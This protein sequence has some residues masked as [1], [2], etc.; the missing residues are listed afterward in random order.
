VNLAS[1]PTTDTSCTVDPQV[2]GA[3]P[4]WTYVTTSQKAVTKPIT[5][6]VFLPR[7][8]RVRIPAGA[9]TATG[10]VVLGDLNTGYAPT[11]ASIYNVTAYKKTAPYLAWFDP[12]ATITMRLTGCGLDSADAAVQTVPGGIPYPKSPDEV[13]LP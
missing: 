11:G 13:Q 5:G 8:G 6:G 10:T 9:T 12:Q 3:H 7:A 2:T 4:A 1:A